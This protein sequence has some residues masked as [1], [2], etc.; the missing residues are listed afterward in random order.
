MNK[1]N[2]ISSKENRIW[3]RRSSICQKIYTTSSKRSDHEREVVLFGNGSG[4]KVADTNYIWGILPFDAHSY[5]NNKELAEEVPMK[6]SYW[7]YSLSVL[8]F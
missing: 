8:M 2:L 4:L 3:L 1:W 5:R 6:I 7:R